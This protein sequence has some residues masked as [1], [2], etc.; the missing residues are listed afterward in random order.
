MIKNRLWVLMAERRTKISIVSD[1]TGISRTTLTNL[2]YNRS[3][4]ID[5]KTL[6]V[7]CQYLSITPGEFFEY[8]PNGGNNS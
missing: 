8:E 4:R 5:F 7:L 6:E 1:A 3:N 2:K